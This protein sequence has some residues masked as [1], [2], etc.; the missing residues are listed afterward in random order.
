MSNKWAENLGEGVWCHVSDESTDGEVNYSEDK[1]ALIVRYQPESE[2][3]YGRKE[4]GNIYR[5]A[6]PVD[7]SR[8][9]N[10]TMEDY[11]EALEQHPSLEPTHTASGL[12]TDA[13]ERKAIPVYTG[14]INYFPKA[15]AA[16]AKISLVGGIQHGQTAET[17]HWDRSKSGDE[18]DAMM[19]H[20]LDGDWEQVAWRAMANLEKKLESE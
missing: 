2:Y 11:Q 17:L 15:I 9:M 7:A 3:P 1:I 14:F 5:F 19:R 18:L 13:K 6:K 20:I 10:T 16:V 12:P 4:W 8:G